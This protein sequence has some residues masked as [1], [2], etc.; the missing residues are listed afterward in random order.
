MLKS[1]STSAGMLSEEVDTRL[2]QSGPPRVGVDVV[3]AIVVM[4]GGCVLPTARLPSWRMSR[5][6]FGI[7]RIAIN[8]LMK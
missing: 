3:L 8:I 7:S 2:L 5:C 6:P 1:T 4:G